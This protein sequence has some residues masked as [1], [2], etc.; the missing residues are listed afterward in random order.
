MIA[1]IIPI[2]NQ[3]AIFV[4]SVVGFL[5]VRKKYASSPSPCRLDIIF[6]LEMVLSTFLI[7]L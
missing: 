3:S 1:V 6:D 7:F 5:N 4:G 2:I